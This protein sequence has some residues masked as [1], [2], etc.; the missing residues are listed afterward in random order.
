MRRILIGVIGGSRVDDEVREVARQIGVEV[1]GHGLSLVCGG[2]SGI[3]EAACEGVHQARGDT[4]SVTIGILPGPDASSA[5]PFIDIAVPTGM[6]IGRNVIVVRASDAVIALDG[7]SGTLS[8]IAYA[9]Q[10]GKPIVALSS[11]GGWA[12]RLAGETLDDRRNDSI[13]SAQTAAEAVRLAL[14]ALKPQ[15]ARAR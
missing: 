9:W 14:S 15:S 10:L 13:L 11:A 6:G 8:E 2:M 3:M 5:N 1:A 12:A 4:D 7:G